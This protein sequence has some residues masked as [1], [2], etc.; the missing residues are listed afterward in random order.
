[1]AKSVRE[2]RLARIEQSIRYH[3]SEIAAERRAVIAA[4]ARIAEGAS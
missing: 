2:Y 1:M 3:Q 4:V